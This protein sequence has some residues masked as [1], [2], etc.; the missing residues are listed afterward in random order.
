MAYT[1]GMYDKSALHIC[2]HLLC[3]VHMHLYTTELAV[4]VEP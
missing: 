4:I 3:F 1:V 2:I